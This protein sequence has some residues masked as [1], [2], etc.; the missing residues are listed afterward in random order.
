MGAF[1]LDEDRLRSVNL[2]QERLRVGGQ[3]VDEAV[4]VYLTD[5]SSFH[6][7]QRQTFIKYNFVFGD[8]GPWTGP[9]RF[10]DSRKGNLQSNVP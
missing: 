2:D 10:G 5:V 4:H 7:N 9:D 1:D 6:T 3:P 8:N